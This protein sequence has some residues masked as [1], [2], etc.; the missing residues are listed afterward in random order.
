MQVPE[1]EYARAGEARI[2][3]QLFGSGSVQLVTCGGPAGHVELFWEE[4]LV[5]RWFERLASF[6]RVAIF[7]RRGTGASDPGDGPPTL[8]Q[9]MEDLEAVMDACGFERAAVIGGGE[10]ARVCALFAATHPE[11]V[12]ALVLTGASARG[13]AVLRPEVLSTLEQIIDRAWGKGELIRA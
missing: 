3:Y 4:P 11:R 9:Y 1:T 2:A 13:A 8:E 7:D 12:S 5:R 6:A 10:A